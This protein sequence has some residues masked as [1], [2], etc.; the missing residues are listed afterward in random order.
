MNYINSLS[1]VDGLSLDRS[2]LNVL[3]VP[4]STFRSMRIIRK[5]TCET[6]TTYGGTQRVVYC[7][8]LSVQSLP[9]KTQQL[10]AK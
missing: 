9:L 2:A 3:S 6:A 10:D 8:S 4:S 7:Q 5:S 1:V